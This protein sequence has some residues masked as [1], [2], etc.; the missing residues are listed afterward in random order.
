MKMDHRTSEV[1][2][3]A[4]GHPAVEDAAAEDVLE[5]LGCKIPDGCIL[6]EPTGACPLCD[7]NGADI[8]AQWISEQPSNH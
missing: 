8:I 4:S 1:A 6:H 5:S 7:E 2:S 3:A